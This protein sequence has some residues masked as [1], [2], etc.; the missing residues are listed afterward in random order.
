MTKEVDYTSKSLGELQESHSRLCAEADGLDLKLPDSLT[1]D[2][3]SQERGAEI[4]KELATLIA[5]SRADSGVAEGGDIG[6][7]EPGSKPAKR[8]KGTTPKVAKETKSTGVS[9]MTTKTKTAKPAKKTAK[10]T[11]AKK[12]VKK[13]AAKKSGVAKKTGPRGEGKTAKVIALMK[14]AG[15][16]TRAEILKLTGWKA[17]SV[18]QLAKSA[19]VKLKVSEERPFHYKVA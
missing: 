19:G 7:K 18:Q 11:T 6:H 4:C 16:V 3:D 1:V 15:G 8:K 10:K 2:F 14:R 9:D 13:A 12:A 17:V 5:T